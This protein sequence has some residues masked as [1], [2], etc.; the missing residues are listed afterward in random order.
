[1]T[2]RFQLYRFFIILTV[3]FSFPTLSGKQEFKGRNKRNTLAIRNRAQARKDETPLM[4]SF[5]YFNNE[6]GFKRLDRSIK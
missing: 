5:I 3:V 1:M 6:M 4:V 2:T